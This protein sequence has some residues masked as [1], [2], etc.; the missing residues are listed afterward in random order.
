MLANC[1]T[2]RS[3]VSQCRIMLAWSK[4]SYPREVAMMT[5]SADSEFFVMSVG[6]GSLLGDAR[7]DRNDRDFI[8]LAFCLARG[9]LND[10]GK[11]RPTERSRSQHNDLVAAAFGRLHHRFRSRARA[12][13]SKQRFNMKFY[14]VQRY[15][16]PSRDRFVGHALGKCGE[17][18]E[19]ARR[20][21]GMTFAFAHR[22][23]AVF[24]SGHANDE[25]GGD[26][27]DGRIDLARVSLARQ[28]ATQAI[29]R[30]AKPD[31]VTDFFCWATAIGQHD[32]GVVL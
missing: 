1:T 7:E 17:H 20:Q 10:H 23:K 9:P 31:D 3:A 4:R 8:P 29:V 26:C 21:Q 11:R 13:F 6:S 25:A 22:A 28:G 27:A 12:E 24:A 30:D 32:V 19:F 2:I 15:L 16:Q 5:T 14:R 18:F